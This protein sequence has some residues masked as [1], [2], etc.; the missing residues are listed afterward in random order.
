MTIK[1]TTTTATASGTIGRC[2]RGA[3]GGQEKGKGEANPRLNPSLILLSNYRKHSL[4]YRFTAGFHT[5]KLNDCS[6]NDYTLRFDTL[7]A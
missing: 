3:G 7:D 6:C 1:V 2:F 4:M 5:S